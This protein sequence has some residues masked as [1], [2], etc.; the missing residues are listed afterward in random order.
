M[1]RGI[2]SIFAKGGPPFT[3]R[4]LL[5][6]FFHR[7]GE[8]FPQYAERGFELIQPG[9]VAQIREAVYLGQIAVQAPRQL[10]LSDSAARMDW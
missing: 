8:A 9:G 6:S 5:R 3:Q 2:G 10:R 1:V 4:L 7:D